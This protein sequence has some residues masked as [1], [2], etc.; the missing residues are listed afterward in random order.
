M[1]RGHTKTR[2]RA[3]IQGHVKNQEYPKLSDAQKKGSTNTQ[4]HKIVG[5]PDTETQRSMG[6]QRQEDTD[7]RLK[8]LWICRKSSTFKDKHAQTLKHSD[9]GHTET[10]TQKPQNTG[11]DSGTLRD[12]DIQTLMQRLIGCTTQ[13]CIKNGTQRLT[14]LQGVKDIRY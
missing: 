9:E 7:T 14:D 8:R 1:T 11:R 10:R 13:G 5:F 4:T 12:G 3:K 2:E 6:T